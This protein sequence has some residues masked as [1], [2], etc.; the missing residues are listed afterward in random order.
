MTAIDL[1]PASRT[2]AI[3][4]PTDGNRFFLET[5][6]R[7][8]DIAWD[9]EH[10]GFFDEL[11][12]TGVPVIS[13]PKSTL[14]QARVIFILAYLA[15][16]GRIDLPVEAIRSAWEFL[17]GPLRH[18]DGGWRRTA[19]RT[20]SLAEPGLMLHR[21]FY[22]H[23]FVILALSQIG[24][25]ITG[26]PHAM[27]SAWTEL[28]QI[29]D[30]PQT[31]GFLEDD[32]TTETLPRRQNPH[33]HLF[34]AC[35]FA[36]GE[37]R[38]PVWQSRAERMIGLFQRRLLDGNSKTLC[39][40]FGPGLSPRPDPLGQIR[41]PGH[42]FEWVWLFNRYEALGGAVDVSRFRADLMRFALKHGS[43]TDGPM[44]DAILDAVAPDGSPLQSTH[45]LWPQT[46]AI[47]ALRSEAARTGD[48][49]LDERAAD[50]ETLIFRHFFPRGAAFWVNQCDGSGNV[51]QPRCLSRLLYHLALALDA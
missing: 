20:G 21:D 27:E 44:A 15:R 11:D 36:W 46:E 26:N 30:D 14:A 5:L 42:H 6:P 50:L 39:E 25:E 33:M 17:M 4:T 22:D 41:E 35:L 16:R 43:V 18:P 28:V 24:P 3:M 10:G 31:G 40:F 29:F 48:Q 8:I 38:D 9:K 13:G 19:G 49:T 34:E 47:K 1:S 12:A 37:T 45:L 2:K 51:T 32:A 23:S 7:W